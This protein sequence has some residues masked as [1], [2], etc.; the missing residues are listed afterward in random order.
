[1]SPDRT[2]QQ[3]TSAGSP[4]PDDLPAVPTQSREDTDVGWGEPSG[5]DDDERLNRER[6]PHWDSV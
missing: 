3:P 4:D 2:P 6:P 5:P 1:M